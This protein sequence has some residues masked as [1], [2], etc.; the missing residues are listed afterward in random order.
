M[1][2]HKLI[3]LNNDV[4]N[5]ALHDIERYL[6][7]HGKHLSDYDGLPQLQNEQGGSTLIH[8]FTTF[9]TSD[10]AEKASTNI[11]MM[12]AEQRAVYDEIIV[13][14]TNPDTA[15][16]TAFFIDGPGGTG[17][18]FTYNTMAAAL[19]SQSKIVIPVA[20]SGIAAEML[21]VARTPHIV[22]SKFPS[23]FRK[24]RLATL[25]ETHPLPNLFKKQV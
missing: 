11:E 14:T 3:P 15:Q 12:N 9:S 23:L 17:K 25:N 2:K 22:P 1:A 16:H 7:I 8:Q 20:T 18:T 24:I 19:R 4:I 6:Q 13:A 5:T 21:D 10:E